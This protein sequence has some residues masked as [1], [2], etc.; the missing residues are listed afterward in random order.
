MFCLTKVPLNQLEKNG[1]ELFQQ[2]NSSYLLNQK[3]MLRP[4]LYGKK[5][6]VEARERKYL[7][8]QRETALTEYQHMNCTDSVEPCSVLVSVDNLRIIPFR[9]LY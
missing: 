9:S 3:S 6:T 5:P 8:R 4:F 2:Y 7:E 1:R